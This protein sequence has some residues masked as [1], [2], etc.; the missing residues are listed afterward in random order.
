MIGSNRTRDFALDDEPSKDTELTLGPMLLAALACGLLLV[1]A[2]CFGAGYVM[3]RR[4]APARGETALPS[5]AGAPAVASQASG[6]AAKPMAKGSSTPA[7]VQAAPVA[8]PEAGTDADIVQPAAATASQP[9]VHPALPAE[10]PAAASAPAHT[11]V[12]GGPMVQIAAV[13]HQ[14]DAD[15]L[16]SALRKRGYAVTARRV[17]GDNLIHVQLGPFASR[18]EASAMAQRLLGD[19]YNAAV[20]P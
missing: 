4:G 11:P 20:L 13:S 12:A 5:A 7:P 2:I 15:V 17:P 9:A 16:M 19:G 8:T 6:G 1:C 10:T 18:T 14:E 3:G